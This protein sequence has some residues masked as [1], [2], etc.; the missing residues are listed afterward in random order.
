MLV[1]VDME[2]EQLYDI[3]LALWNRSRADLLRNKYRFERL[4]DR[5]CIIVRYDQV[6]SAMLPE[7][8]VAAVLIS[9]YYLDNSYYSDHNLAGLM[10]LLKICTK[11]LLAICGGLQLLALA[12]EAVIG[13]LGSIPSG[14]SQLHLA[15][16]QN[17]SGVE[18]EIGFQTVTARI[19]HR[20]FQHLQ[21]PPIFFQ[22]HYWEVKEVPDGFDVLATSD[23]CAIQAIGHW[24]KPL[25]VT[26]FHPEAYDD[27]YSDGRQFLKNFFSL[28]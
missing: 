13:P 9:G 4:S 2:H 26:Q 10:D 22:S 6:S 12:H 27:R 20:L 11:P 23:L 28:I 16:V 21:E 1:Y 3:D 25:F 17:I 14:L 15:S 18:Q 19:R 7:V 8:N 24:E 5:P